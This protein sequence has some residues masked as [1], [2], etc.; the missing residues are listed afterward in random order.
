MDEY[1]LSSPAGITTGSITEFATDLPSWPCRGLDE[2]SKGARLG[3][4]V[5]EPGWGARLGSQVGEPGWAHRCAE[6]V[7]LT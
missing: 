7:K 5:G 2:P 3:S 1:F 4:Q 6:T